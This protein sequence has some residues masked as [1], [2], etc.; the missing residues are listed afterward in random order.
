MALNS[1]NRNAFA[2]A[3]P[4]DMGQ[5]RRAPM[6]LVEMDMAVDECGQE[7]RALKIKALAGMMRA[8]RRMQRRNQAAG[9]FDIGEVAV[10]ETRVGQE[11]QTRF[12]RFAA[13]YV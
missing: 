7:E 2:H 5:A 4:L 13:A 12:R 9:D 11:H 3:A 6:R 10:G 1:L 8:S